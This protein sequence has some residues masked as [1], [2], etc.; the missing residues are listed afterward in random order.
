LEHLRGDM[1]GGKGNDRLFHGTSGSWK[2][3]GFTQERKVTRNP[4]AEGKE[5][6]KE[7]HANVPLKKI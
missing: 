6:R 4:K 7:P 1:G 2:I 3:Q 5:P